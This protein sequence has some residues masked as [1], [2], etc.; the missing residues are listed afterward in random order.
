MRLRAKIISLIK[1][2]SIVDF[3]ALL[4]VFVAAVNLVAAMIVHFG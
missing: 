3:A 4:I 2:I 1:S